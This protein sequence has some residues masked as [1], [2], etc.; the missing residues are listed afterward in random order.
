MSELSDLFAAERARRDL[1]GTPDP[2]IRERFAFASSLLALRRASG[3]SQRELADASGVA[4]AEISKIERALTVPT[5][6][7]AERLLEPLGYQLVVAARDA[8]EPERELV[9]V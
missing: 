9:G 7:R 3:W 4:Q 1:E 6:S 8:T 2:A 5:I